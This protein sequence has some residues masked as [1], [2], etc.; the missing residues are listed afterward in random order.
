MQHVFFN[1]KTGILLLLI[2]TR[3]LYANGATGDQQ[4]WWP[5]QKP[6]SSVVT[7]T[8]H[9]SA[10][11]REMNLAQSISGLAARALNAGTNTEGVWIDTK[12]SNYTGYYTSFIQRL[13][14][15][16]SGK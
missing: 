4:G 14:V 3:A 2:I 1:L 13:K 5:E 9:S 7:C 10:D 6:P 8:I 16:E 11:L 15:N 12:N